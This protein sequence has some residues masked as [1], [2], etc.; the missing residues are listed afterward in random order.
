[1]VLMITAKPCWSSPKLSRQ[2]L[3]AFIAQ[4]RPCLIGIEACS[5]AHH[6]ARQFRQHGH[7]VKLMAP[8]FVTPYRLS[9]KG[10]KDGAADAAAICEAARRPHMRFGPVKEE[11][12]QII[13]SLHRH[14]MHDQSLQQAFKRALSRTGM[15]KTAPPDP[16]RHS[17]AT[18]A[19]QAG[20][21][22][23]TVQELLGHADVAATRICAHV[24][25][26]DAGGIRSTIDSMPEVGFLDA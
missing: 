24:S 10:G 12:Q 3:P 21:D 13:L 18:A 26:V 25:K 22:I 5:G 7:T 2:H 20:Y 19:L 1:M 16:L 14:H 8:K 11:H 4:L 6:L 17:I 23:R 15:A 9:G